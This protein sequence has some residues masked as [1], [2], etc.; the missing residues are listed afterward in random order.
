MTGL[1]IDEILVR[2]GQDAP[3]VLRVSNGLRHAV[4]T[5]TSAEALL[6][7]E[8]MVEADPGSGDAPPEPVFEHRE[9]DARLLRKVSKD[10]LAA[11]LDAIDGV[12]KPVRPWV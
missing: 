3:S 5:I 2:D 4:V 10:E 1:R 6:L 7:A 8:L 9:P 11:V 12:R